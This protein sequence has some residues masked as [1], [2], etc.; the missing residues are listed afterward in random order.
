M[1]N[2]SII[3]PCYNASGHIH[4]TVNSVRSQTYKS[5]EHLLINDGSTDNTEKILADLALEGPGLSLFSQVNGGVA[6][7]R[8]R[9]LSEIHK[10]AQY[11]LFLDHDDILDSEAIKTLVTQLEANPEAVAAYGLP[12]Y[13]GMPPTANQTADITEW[14]RLRRGFT[15]NKILDWP[16]KAP[17]NFDV[18]AVGNCISTPGQIL[19]R[20]SALDAIGLFDVAAAPS[21]DWDMWIRLSRKGNIS[22]VDTCVTGWRQHENNQSHQIRR[23]AKSARYVQQ[24]MIMSEHNTPEQAHLARLVYR[25]VEWIDLRDKLRFTQEMLRRGNLIEAVMQFQRAARCLANYFFAFR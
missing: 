5:W 12:Y 6:S 24:K 21:D 22:F 19:I 14:S 17:I 3:T 1:P 4:D 25:A 16:E 15:S 13:F 18:L 11:V 20:R 8:N 10:E 7:A 9:G 2:V 23:M